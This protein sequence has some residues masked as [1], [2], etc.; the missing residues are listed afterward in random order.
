MMNQRTDEVCFENI[1]PRG[2]RVRAWF[3]HA[4][5]IFGLG[6]TAVLLL[7]SADWWWRLLVFGPFAAAVA[8]WLQAHDRT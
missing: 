6:L 1:G 8:N 2:R 4:A 5:F 3:G 7:T